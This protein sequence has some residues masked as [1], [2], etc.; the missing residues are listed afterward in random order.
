MAWHLS[1]FLSLTS[2][3][4]VERVPPNPEA[5]CV[6]CVSPE[7]RKQDVELVPLQGVHKPGVMQRGTKRAQG[8]AYWLGL[9]D[10]VPHAHPQGCCMAR[11][12]R[13]G[14]ALFTL[15]HQCEP[16]CLHRA[17]DSW[18][19]PVGFT[20]PLQLKLLCSTNPS[21]QQENKTFSPGQCQT[22]S[23]ASLALEERSYRRTFE[24]MKKEMTKGGDQKEAR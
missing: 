20:L 18:M 6:T 2:C 14:L 13:E 17:R 5:N 7:P 8:A 10:S 19:S 9:G 23:E 15:M 11:Q 4:A 24:Q 21:E 1:T 16:A 3:Q 22:Q 12:Q